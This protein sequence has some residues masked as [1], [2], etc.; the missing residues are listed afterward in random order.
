M[1]KMQ[2]KPKTHPYASQIAEATAAYS[3]YIVCLERPEAERCVTALID[4]AVAAFEKKPEG[5]K[6]G[7]A[8]DHLITVFIS[9]RAGSEPSCAVF[10]N[11]S[12]PWRIEHAQATKIEDHN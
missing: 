11:L 9:E 5:A 6:H 1:T 3:K 2:E 4:R 12:T 7:I 8:F 10:F